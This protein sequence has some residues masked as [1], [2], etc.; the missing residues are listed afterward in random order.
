MSLTAE[1]IEK[2]KEEARR[3]LEYSTYTLCMILGVDVD[4]LSSDMDIPVGTEHQ[5]YGSYACLRNQVAALE[6]L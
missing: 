6:N 3:Y 5:Q 4:S 2:S 1:Q